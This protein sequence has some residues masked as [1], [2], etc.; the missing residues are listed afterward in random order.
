MH[1]F[2]LGNYDIFVADSIFH[3]L[4]FIENMSIQ[5]V[6]VQKAVDSYEAR[7]ELPLRY[8]LRK[9]TDDIHSCQS[10]TLLNQ[11]IGKKFF[12]KAYKLTAITLISA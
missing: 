9:N 7:V 1:A 12:K 5:K 6:E 2:Y 8:L 11:N 10:Q 3:L 4:V